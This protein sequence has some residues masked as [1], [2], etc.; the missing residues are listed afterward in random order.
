MYKLVGRRIGLLLSVV[1]LVFLVRLGLAQL[2]SPPDSNINA[3]GKPNFYEADN[4]LW[5]F[6]Q[7]EVSEIERIKESGLR[8]WWLFLSEVDTRAFAGSSFVPGTLGVRFD[9]DQASHYLSLRAS[10]LDREGFGALLEWMDPETLHLDRCSGDFAD[11]L[12]EAHRRA[13]PT[14]VVVTAKGV[15]QYYELVKI[16]EELGFGEWVR[17]I[18]PHPGD[19]YR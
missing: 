19:E 17:L 13:L 2:L 15:A 5:Y 6:H 9:P 3:F 1:V 8:P 7:P 16:V 18:W 11:V 12:T 10:K 14:D 4:D